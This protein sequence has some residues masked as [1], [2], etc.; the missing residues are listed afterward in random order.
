[1]AKIECTFEGDVNWFIEQLAELGAENI[2][3]IKD[4]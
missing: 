1:M 2:I 3:E 4:I